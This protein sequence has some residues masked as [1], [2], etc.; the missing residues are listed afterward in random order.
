MIKKRVN[1]EREGTTWET[2]W[3]FDVR[4]EDIGVVVR[5]LKN[6]G[7]NEEKV[8]SA[9]ETMTEDLDNFAITQVNSIDRKMVIIIANPT[10]DIEFFNSFTHELWHCCASICATE[11]LDMLGEPIAYIQGEFGQKLEKVI[12][13]YLRKMD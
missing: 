5:A 7:M 10:S 6:I 12:E 13:Y 2:I 8:S 4:Y 1:I 9:K 3:F 11:G